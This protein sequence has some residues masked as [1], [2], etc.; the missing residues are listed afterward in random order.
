MQR[1]SFI[2]ITESNRSTRRAW[3]LLLVL[4]GVALGMTF[5]SG[6]FV[7]AEG[8]SVDDSAAGRTAMLQMPDAPGGAQTVCWPT[9]ALP[10]YAETE[11]PGDAPTGDTVS[12]RQGRHPRGGHLALAPAIITTSEAFPRYLLLR[13]LRL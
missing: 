2:A 10:I 13:V 9:N 1:P 4:L 11:P 8:F 12:I 7:A 3:G 5:G 6:S